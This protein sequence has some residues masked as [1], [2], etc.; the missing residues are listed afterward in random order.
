M[1]TSREEYLKFLKEATAL[2]LSS[3]KKYDIFSEIVKSTPQIK[4]E[5]YEDIIELL[6]DRENLGS[7]IIAPKVALAHVETDLIDELVLSCAF[8]KEGIYNWSLSETNDELKV[9]FMLI[10]PQKTNR[11]LYIEIV[12]KLMVQF[13]NEENLIKLANV[14]NV[15]EIKCI[16]INN[17]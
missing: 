12:K 7:T 6:I 10:F 2:T 13:S 17:C 9:I 16:L 14:Q 3:K 15:N 5:C 4:E 11:H 8:S 1:E